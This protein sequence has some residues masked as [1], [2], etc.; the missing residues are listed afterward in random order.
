MWQQL[1][2]T[3]PARIA[4]RDE[5]NMARAL[6]AGCHTLGQIGGGMLSTRWRGA[7]NATAC[8]GRMRS[9]TAARA[10]TAGTFS[11]AIREKNNTQR[12]AQSSV[13]FASRT[14]RDG[15]VSESGS[16]KWGTKMADEKPLLIYLATPYSPVGAMT[17]TDSAM[18][19]S[20][21]AQRAC[22]IAG[23]L[24]REGYHVYSPIAASHYIAVYGDVKGDW[25]T[26]KAYDERMISFCD[27]LWVATEM[28]GWQS[29][30]G[31]KAE[32]AY[33]ESIGKPV[34]YYEGQ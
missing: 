31:V 22:E 18:L 23:R 19:K 2:S 33:A 3:T 21:R 28:D 20:E 9:M 11:P 10:T 15:P 8:F 1:R 7:R 5:F 4:A 25:K 16:R 29:S 24:I 32:I 34:R 6:A 12:S 26:W 17:I 27:E 13:R 30:V 14:E